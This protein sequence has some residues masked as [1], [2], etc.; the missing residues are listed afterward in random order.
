MSGALALRTEDRD[1]AQVLTHAAAPWNRMR[2]A[3]L[4]ELEAAV[5]A[6]PSMTAFAPCC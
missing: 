2:F 4:D 3:Y 5:E 6:P 1:G